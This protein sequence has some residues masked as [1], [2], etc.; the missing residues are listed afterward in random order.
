MTRETALEAGRRS[1][2]RH[3]AKI[4]AEREAEIADIVRGRTAELEADNVRL[5][6]ALLHFGSMAASCLRVNTPEWMEL[7]A[8]ELNK[9]CEAGGDAD[10]WKF[11]GWGLMKTRRA[12]DE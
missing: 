12:T 11:D 9:V 8:D 5:R 1:F 3:R 7:L 4:A 6:A 10:R 2:E